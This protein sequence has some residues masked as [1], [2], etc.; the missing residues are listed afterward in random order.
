[1]TAIPQ[2]AVDLVKKYEG[3]RA[4][5]YLCPAGYATAGFGT[6]KG[7]K[8]GMTITREDAEW[9]LMRDLREVADGLL[10]LVTVE[11]TDN[12]WAALISFGYN[13]GLG[14]FQR[15]MLR[16]MI[17]RGEFAAV[18][19]ELLRWCHVGRRVLPGLVARREAEGKL[20]R[21]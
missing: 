13:L 15:S 17:N 19:N 11:L 2:A 6:R 3:F 20:W 14:A 9:L 1:M 10:P 21:S 8:I 12:Q 4:H 18:P 16:D 5:A 7:I